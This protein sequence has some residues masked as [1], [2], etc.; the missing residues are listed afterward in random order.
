MGSH[1]GSANPIQNGAPAGTRPTASVVPT[2]GA[3]LVSQMLGHS[4]RGLT[5]SICAHL[6]PGARRQESAVQR[7]D[8]LLTGAG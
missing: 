5:M 1:S 6:T 2:V 7:L 3:D 4:S 8:L